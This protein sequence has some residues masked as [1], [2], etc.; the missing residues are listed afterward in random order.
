MPT[1]PVDHGC[2]ASQAITWHR[3]A[4]SLAGYSS[5]ATPSDDPVPRRSTRATAYPYSRHRRSYSGRYDAVASSLRYGSAS[6]TTGAAR[7]SSAPSGRYKLTASRTPSSIGIQLRR[8][9]MPHSPGQPRDHAT[10]GS[11]TRSGGLRREQTPR[12]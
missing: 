10:L 5:V 2:A 12:P 3:S 11:A 9:P 4:C 8:S 6:S 7:P 1:A